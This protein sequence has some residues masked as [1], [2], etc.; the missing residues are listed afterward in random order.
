MPWPPRNRHKPSKPQ[1][2][3]HA[4]P[5]PHA[6]KVIRPLELTLACNS[7]GTERLGPRFIGHYKQPRAFRKASSEQ[8]GIQYLSKKNSLDDPLHLHLLVGLP[9]S[10]CWAIF[11]WQADFAFLGKL[12]LR[13]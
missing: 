12:N 4:I 9:G 13:L 5:A 6:P 2:L 7:T 10:L 1:A 8:L 11:P 3:R